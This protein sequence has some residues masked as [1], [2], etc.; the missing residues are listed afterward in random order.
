MQGLTFDLAY[1]GTAGVKGESLV[2]IHYLK[3]D[4]PNEMLQARCKRCD[5]YGNGR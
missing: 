3:G 2:R 5:G 1:A 4:Y